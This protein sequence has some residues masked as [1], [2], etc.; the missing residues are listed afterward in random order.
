MSIFMSPSTSRIV[1]LCLNYYCILFQLILHEDV[2]GYQVRYNEIMIMNVSSS[3]NSLTFTALPVP[4][5]ESI[6]FVFAAVTAFSRFGVG[7]TSEA[8]T[9]INGN[10]NK[11]YFLI[12]T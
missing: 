1:K 9:T 6:G 3:T 8:Y 2:T 11:V 10:N 7:P 4:D 5:E 12:L